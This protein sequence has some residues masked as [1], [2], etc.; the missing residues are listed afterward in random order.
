MSIF[1]IYFQS[2][3]PMYCV[4]VALFIFHR[5][6]RCV[7]FFFPVLTFNSL[8]SEAVRGL[9]EPGCVDRCA[10]PAEKSASVIDLVSPNNSNIGVFALVWFY[11]W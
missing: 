8:I 2:F 5:S 1:V 3:I 6:Y 7:V 9:K 11:L 4:S 10:P